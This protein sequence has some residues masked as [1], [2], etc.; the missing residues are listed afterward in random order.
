MAVRVERVEAHY[1]QILL[2]SSYRESDNEMVVSWYCCQSVAIPTRLWSERQR[3][4]H[5]YLIYI[6]HVKN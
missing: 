3:D 4:R 5:G 1:T 2:F 6:R